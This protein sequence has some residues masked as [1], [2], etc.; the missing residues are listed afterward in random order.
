MTALARAAIFAPYAA[1]TGFESQIMAA[2]HHRCNRILLTEEQQDQISAVLASVRKNDLVAVTYFLN[3]PG[4][5]GSGGYAEG[6][7]LEITGKVL[8]IAPACRCLRVGDQRNWAD[9]PFDAILEI[10]EKEF[11]QTGK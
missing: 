6:E 10:H 9:I 8:S 11:L 3:D 1:L 4:T 2:G 7:Y 5:D